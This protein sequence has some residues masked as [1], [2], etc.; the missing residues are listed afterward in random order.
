[1]RCCLLDDSMTNACYNAG[2]WQ[3]QTIQKSYG[4]LHLFFLHE[5]SW[6]LEIKIPNKSQCNKLLIKQSEFNKK[7]T[8]LESYMTSP[9]RW[10]SLPLSHMVRWVKVML[11]LYNFWGNGQL[12][13]KWYTN[14]ILSYSILLKF[15]KEK[16]YLVQNKKKFLVSHLFLGQI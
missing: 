8:N 14:R 11:L 3:T 4:P 15:L 7:E 5:P 10:Q 13:I 16:K 6:S 9:H 12:D 2:W 1:M